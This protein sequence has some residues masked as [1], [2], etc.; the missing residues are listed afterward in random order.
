MYQMVAST[1]TAS[2]LLGDQLKDQSQLRVPFKKEERRRISH[3][4]R[5]NY[6]NIP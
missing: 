5:N 6:R 2:L 1:G 3:S 4:L